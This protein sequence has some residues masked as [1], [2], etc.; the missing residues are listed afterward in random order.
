MNGKLTLVSAS[1]GFGKTTLIGDWIAG[2]GRPA[3]WLSLDK[4]DNDANRFLVHFVAALQTIED[5]FGRSSVNALQSQQPPSTET[6]L[7]ML[8]NE[9]SAH[10]HKFVFVLDD[11]H[12]IDAEWLGDSIAFLLDHLPAQM[13]LV[14]ATRENPQL[15]LGRL[16]ARGHLSELR[17]ADLRFTPGEAAAFL[18]QAMGLSLTADETNALETRTEGWIAGLQLAALSMKG[19]KD[20][21]SFIREFA[22]DNRYIMDYLVEEVLQRQSESIRSFLLRTSILDRLHGPLCD[23]VAG[24]E[25]GNARLELLERGN[26]FVVPLDDK[27]RWYRYHHLFAEV[28]HM[29]LKADHPDQ[30]AMLHLRASVWYEQNGMAAD[31]IRHSLAAEDYVRTADLVEQ[32]IPSLRRNR[33]EIAMLGWIQALPVELIR[34]RPVLCVWYAG[35]LLAGGRL[36]AVEDRLRDAERW[37]LALADQNGRQQALSAGMIVLD[38][39]EFRRLPGLITVYRAGLALVLGNV[40]AVQQYARKALEL[41]PEEDG[42][43]RGAATALLGLASWRSGDLEEARRMFA[44][45]LTRVKQA[46]AVSDAINGA[47]AIAVICMAQGRLREAMR[48]Y[49]R[50]LQLAVEHGDPN[51]R[52][53]ADIYVGMSEIYRELNDLRAAERHLLKSK[54]QGAHAGFPQFRYRWCISMSRLREAQGDLN[55]ALDLLLEAEN[56]FASDFFLDVRPTAALKTRLRILQGRL[57]GALDWVRDQGLSVQDDLCYAREFEH[58]TLARVLLAQNKIDHADRSLRDALELLGRLLQEAEA[59]GRI[60]SMIEIQV[61]QAIAHHMQGDTPAALRQLERSLT[62]AEPEGYVRTFVDEGQPMAN[63]LEIAANQGIAPAYARRLLAA[64][65]RVDTLREP[66]TK[67]FKKLLLEPLSERERDVLRFLATDLSGPDIARELIIS[68]NTLRTHT[69]NIYDKLEANSRR[70]AVRRAIE[71]GLL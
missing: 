29:H 68:L 26:F 66:R 2:C 54:E 16:R 59:G 31:A 64:L 30:V 42:L 9:I 17:E 52:G 43:P 11:Y 57:G 41:V 13:H 20:I 71:L 35:A 53:T 47:N 7:T 50:G 1:A 38:E 63:L 61:V 4:G 46:G 34:F 69:K 23:A 5:S 27:R 48:T 32:A 22:G 18:D 21:P 51:L 15:P 39:E 10:P 56:L 45:G 55:G 36:E 67:P 62:L 28:L 12:Q 33:D 40:Q 70:E 37:L 19:H 25:E 65:G 14:I 58:V 6:I 24:Q 3:A 44:E 49:E 8:L 60:G